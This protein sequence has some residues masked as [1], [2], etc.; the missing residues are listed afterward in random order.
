MNEDFLNNLN[1]GRGS[2]TKPKFSSLSDF[3]SRVDPLEDHSWE[4]SLRSRSKKYNSV[5]G[6]NVSGVE[7]SAFI[8]PGGLHIIIGL[9][10]ILTF[11]KQI[12]A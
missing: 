4:R 10:H 6:R 8:Q 1:H 3:E 2:V 9:Y 12:M 5:I 7:D 11:N